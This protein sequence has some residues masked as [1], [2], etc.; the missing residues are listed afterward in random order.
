M[1]ADL[2]VKGTWSAIKRSLRNHAA[3]VEGEFDHYLAEY[4]WRRRRGHSLDD[5][6]RE[7]LRAITTL[8]PPMEK[9]V[10]SNLPFQTLPWPA[11]S[12]DLSPV[13]HVWEQLKRQM[14]SCHSEHDL[15]LSV[16]DLWAHLPQ[17]NIRCLINSMAA[18]IAAGGGPTRH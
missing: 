18:C 8:Y 15:E 2:K 1:A 10:P 3:H 14:L 9:D 16:Q 13:E 4:M 6:F 17:D 11:R 5:V 7:F 12:P